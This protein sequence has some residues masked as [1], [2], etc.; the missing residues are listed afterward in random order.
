M[1][2]GLQAEID[3][4]VEMTRALHRFGTPAHRLEDSMCVLCERLGLEGSFFATPTAIWANFAGASG[5]QTF[6]VRAESGAVDLGKLT[7]LDE[8][9]RDVGARVTSPAEGEA[10]LAEILAQPPAYGA[11]LTVASFAAASGAAA[12]FFEGGWRE[13][14]V[15]SALGLLLGLLAHTTARVDGWRRLF[16]PVGGLLVSLLAV[17][18][19]AWVQPLSVYVTTVAGLITLVPGLTLTVAMTELSTGHLTSGTA[20]FTG[21][22]VVFVSIGFG[23]ALGNRLGGMIFAAPLAV[24]PAT[25]PNWAAW[26]A[27]ALA[28][29]AFT[30]LFRARRGDLRWILP[31]CVIAFA[32]ARLGTRALGPELGVFL[33][34]LALGL[35]SNLRARIGQVPARVMLV[36]GLMMLVPGSLG[37]RSL[38]SLL[39]RDVVSGIQLAFTMLMVAVA[40]VAGLLV[41]NVVAPPKRAL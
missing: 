4:V 23:V 34:A 9:I 10:R 30:V 25:L 39:E 12:V 14:G 33:G 18:A 35:S 20:R 32:G 17:A 3:F 8:L 13:V 19:G 37:F 5:Q 2:S 22:W 24:E 15:T 31:A 29:V 28:P 26:I 36:P 6:L 38:S 7:L 11:S 1:K 40:L 27:L 16:E 41:A 21:A